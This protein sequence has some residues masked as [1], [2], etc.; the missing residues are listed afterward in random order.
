MAEINNAPHPNLIPSCP[1][2]CRDFNPPRDFSTI[3][4]HQLAPSSLIFYSFISKPD[5][6]TQL[7]SISQYSWTH[8]DFLPQQRIVN[9]NCTL[10]IVFVLEPI[11][12]IFFLYGT[13]TDIK[14][15]RSSWV[16]LEVDLAI[17]STYLIEAYSATGTASL[18][19]IYD[20][21]SHPVIQ[22]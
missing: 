6:E 12:M 10:N 7:S 1:N 4:V 8:D 9:I 5:N 17:G 11:K 20:C 16:V 21:Q 14:E 19:A 22:R 18:G 15:Y 2:F 3:A 13:K